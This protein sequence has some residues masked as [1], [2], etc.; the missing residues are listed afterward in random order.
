MDNE[1]DIFLHVSSKDS[2]SY[3]PHNTPAVFRVKLNT[4][5]NLNGSWEMGVCDVN[6]Q[7]VNVG[8]NAASLKMFITCSICSGFI[9][10]GKQTRAIRVLGMS[11]NVVETYAHI[12]YIPVGVRFID[13]IEFRIL[14]DEM[15]EVSFGGKGKTETGYTSIT[16]HIKRS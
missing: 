13:C 6:M 10:D 8:E 14:N 5:L 7:N 9:V 3:F 15:H 12:L 1:N 11:E 4:T 16:L 2:L